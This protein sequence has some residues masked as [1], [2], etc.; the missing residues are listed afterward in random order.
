MSG[1]ARSDYIVSPTYDWALFFGLVWASEKRN[2]TRL[3]RVDRLVLGK[4]V[5][6]KQV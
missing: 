3:F 2:L 5:A 4:P 1:V 6:A